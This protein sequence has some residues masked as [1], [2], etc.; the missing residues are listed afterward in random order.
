MEQPKRQE[1]GPEEEDF[2][3]HHPELKEGEVF[4]TN[5]A[6]EEVFNHLVWKTKRRGLVVYGRDGKRE[7]GGFP[8]FAKKSEAEGAGVNPDRL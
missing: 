1:L 3:K 2:N 8:V 4:V 6:D 7:I 5:C